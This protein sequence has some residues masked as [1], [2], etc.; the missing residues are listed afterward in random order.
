[1]FI[2]S[3]LFY[4]GAREFVINLWVAVYTVCFQPSPVT[5]GIPTTDGAIVWRNK[6]K[7]SQMSTARP[8]GVRYDYV[9]THTYIYIYMC[10]CVCVCVCVLVMFSLS[11]YKCVSICRLLSVKY[12][13]KSRFYM[14]RKTAIL[15]Y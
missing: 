2:I 11:V 5:R 9:S 7:T 15:L 10:V 4:T 12:S 13:L 3:Y 14:H 8:P 1:M 6:L